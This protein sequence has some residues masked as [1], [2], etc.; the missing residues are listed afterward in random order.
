MS[1]V[2][3]QPITLP[4]GVELTIEAGRVNVTGPKGQLSCPVLTGLNVTKDEAVVT[5]T[6]RQDTAATQRAFGLM[7]TLVANMVIGVSTGFE[8]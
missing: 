5:V 1:R 8:R 3:R 2:G 6:K 7:R 4:A